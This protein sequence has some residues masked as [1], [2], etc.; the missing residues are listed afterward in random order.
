MTGRMVHGTQYV[1][2]DIRKM[3][4]MMDVT[5]IQTVPLYQTHRQPR[6]VNVR[7]KL[8]MDH[9]HTVAQ[10]KHVMVTIRLAVVPR[11]GQRVLAARHGVNVPAEQSALHA[12]LGII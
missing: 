3:Q 11:R 12:I 6:T 5:V 2:R 1:Q 10:H 9:V 7:A 8:T 4:M